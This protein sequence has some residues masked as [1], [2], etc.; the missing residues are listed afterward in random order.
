M[1]GIQSSLYV[2]FCSICLC[3]AHFST[4]WRAILGNRGIRRRQYAFVLIIRLWLDDLTLVTGLAHQVSRKHTFHRPQENLPI[5]LMHRQPRTVLRDI[6]GTLRGALENPATA[7]H[8]FCKGICCS[9]KGPLIV[10]RNTLKAVLTLMRYLQICISS[11]RDDQLTAYAG[12]SM[13]ADLVTLLGA[14]RIKMRG[15]AS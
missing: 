10:R 13:T 11:C 14:F 3:I 5:T 9:C 4:K 1:I 12:K 7:I 6:H 8:K 2:R 15:Y